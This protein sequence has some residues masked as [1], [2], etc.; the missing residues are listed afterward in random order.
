MTSDYLLPNRIV[1][2]GTDNGPS[3]YSFE[4]T[5]EVAPAP[6]SGPLEAEDTL[7]GSAVQGEVSGDVDAYFYSGDVV[8]YNLQGAATVVIEDRDG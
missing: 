8:S 6:G 5:G 4:V 1:I 2:D 3:Q 7:S